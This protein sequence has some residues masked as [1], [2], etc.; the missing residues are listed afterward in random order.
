M[1]ICD[2]KLKLALTI[3]L[4]LLVAVPLVVFGSLLATGADGASKNQTPVVYQLEQYSDSLGDCVVFVYHDGAKVVCKKLKCELITKAPDWKVHCFR[5]DDRIEW[6]NEIQKFNGET[7]SNPFARL[8]PPRQA[9]LTEVGHGAINGL[10]Y[11]KFK[12]PISA[13]DQLYTTKDLAVAPPL[14]EFLARL[15]YTPKAEGIPLYRC[16][17]NRPD[18][19]IEEA[20]VGIIKIA[21]NTDLRTGLVKKLE[22]KG[23]KKIA[24]N[25]SEFMVP[26]GFKQ[27][28]EISQ[29]SYSSEKKGEFNEIFDAIGFKTDARNLKSGAKTK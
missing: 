16:V 24:F 22:T 10:K 23:W 6:S 11:T 4:K 21:A 13:N 7:M 17:D 19:K 20:K 9:K 29:V 14:E 8:R 5:K 12:T 3:Q 18:R 2:R 28:R 27:L 25:A 15:Y 26:T 1:I